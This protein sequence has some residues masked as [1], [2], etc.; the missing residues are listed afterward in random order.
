MTLSG[1]AEDFLLL[2]NA[3][4]LYGHVTLSGKRNGAVHTQV[5]TGDADP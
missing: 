2:L 3:A 5:T 4:P 1:M